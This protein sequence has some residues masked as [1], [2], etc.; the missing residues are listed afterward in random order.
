MKKIKHIKLFENFSNID[1]ELVR[2]L[3]MICRMFKSECL[4]SSEHPCEEFG[5][6]EELIE[7]AEKTDDRRIKSI[8]KKM[9]RYSQLDADGSA[10][11]IFDHLDDRDC[12]YVAQF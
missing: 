8:L 6:G 5:E 9:A 12:D 2:N 1:P 10:E 11:N 4:G 7:L 3:K